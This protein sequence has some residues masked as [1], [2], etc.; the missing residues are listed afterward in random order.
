MSA[1]G[2]ENLN[3]REHPDGEP[4]AL[5]DFQPLLCRTDASERGGPGFAHS[6]T[7]RRPEEHNEDDQGGSD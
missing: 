2:N 7:G 3:G 6:K 1:I 5:K 4:I